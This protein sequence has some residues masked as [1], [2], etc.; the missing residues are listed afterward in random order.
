MDVVLCVEPRL[1]R[2]ALAAFLRQL[3]NTDSVTAVAGPDA[4]VRSVRARADLLVLGAK[5]PGADD[6]VE[7]LTNLGNGTPILALD[8]D[9]QNHS[10]LRRAANHGRVSCC[11]SAVRGASLY[12]A[13]RLVM[14]GEVVLTSELMTSMVRDI[15]PNSDERPRT[16]HL[17]AKLTPREREV[18]DMLTAGMSRRQI[19]NSLDISPHTVR[20]H[21][22]NIQGKL[23][24]HSQIA[25]AA[26]ARSV[27]P[28]GRDSPVPTP[29][30]SAR[31]PRPEALG[32]AR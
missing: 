10:F 14:V 12:D 23:E 15:R 22:R 11:A 25:A 13:I 28:E 30:T 32:V 9:P 5:L 19:A 24:V 7:A 3:P 16:D 18:L 17:L 1:F 21:L 26:A 20:T 31:H 27:S 29:T 4:A 6:A 2:D 8:V